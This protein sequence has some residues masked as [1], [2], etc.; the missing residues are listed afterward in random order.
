MIVVRCHSQ[1]DPMLDI[2][3]NLLFVSVIS[4]QRVQSVAMRHPANQAAF[5]AQRNHH[6][7]LYRQIATERVGILLQQRVY[8][9]EQLHHSFVLS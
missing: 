6:V 8:Q 2:Q 7:S 4:D 3:Q 9:T 1:H 5:R